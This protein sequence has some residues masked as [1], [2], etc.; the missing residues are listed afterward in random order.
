MLILAI[1]LDSLTSSLLF[2]YVKSISPPKG[3]FSPL[4]IPLLNIPASGIPLRPEFSTVCDI[5][6]IPLSHLITLDDIQA[7]FKNPANTRWILVDHNKLQGELGQKY[8]PYVRGVIDHHDEEQ[9]VSQDTAPE[10]RVVE[11]VGSCTSLVTRYCQ[12]TWN[13]I[14]TTS[15]SSGAANAQSEFPIDDAAVTRTWDAQVAKLALASILIDTANLTAPGK[16]E[17]VDRE[18]VESLE[19]K[20]YLSP[21]DS[22]TWNRDAFYKAIDDAKRNIDGLSVE[23][24]LIKDYKEWEEG[25]GQR[26]GISSTVVSLPFL[27]QKAKAEGHPSLSVPISNLITRQNLST[28]ALTAAFT[29]PSGDFQRELLLHDPGPDHTAVQTFLDQA[30]EKLELTELEL[31]KGVGMGLLRQTSFSDEGEWINFWTQTD[32]TKSRKQVAPMLREALRK[33]S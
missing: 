20:I 22:G 3:G 32:L 27:A 4:Y 6:G 30:I 13:A 7:G 16:V 23:D 12:Q 11:K 26:L 15:L 9:S 10:P 2:A 31:E 33:V 1:D 19:S 24:I 5:S 25:N 8:A 28:F 21:R 18:A 17:Q 14:S 29:S